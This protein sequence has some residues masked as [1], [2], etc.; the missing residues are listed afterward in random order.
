M[1]YL[2]FNPSNLFILHRRFSSLVKTTDS[3]KSKI[4]PGL[5]KGKRS[6]FKT[7]MVILIVGAKEHPGKYHILESLAFSH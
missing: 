7:G 2:C 5:P 1:F 3:N 6:K 4:F